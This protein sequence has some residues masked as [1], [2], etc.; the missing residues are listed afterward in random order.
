L[1]AIAAYFAGL[2]LIYVGMIASLLAGLAG[3]VGALPILLISAA[4]Q[5]LQD[6]LLGAAAGIMM[7]AASFSLLVPALDAG[8]AQTGDIL[9]GG[10]LAA[11]GLMLG[12]A[13]ISLAH[14]Y[15]PHEHFFKGRDQF[16]DS[17]VRRIW[18]F[19]IAITLH[20]IPEGLAVGVGFGG[21]NVANGL[22]LTAGIFL[23]NL[24]EGFVVALAL[25]SL[26]YGR[27]TAVLVAL[28]T[29]A[30]ETIGG[31]IGA[32]FVSLSQAFLP[33]GLAGAAGAMLFVISHEIIPETH[34]NGHE[35]E[36]TFGLVAGFAVMMIL[37]VLTAELI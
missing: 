22:A 3:G 14:K 13:G 1:S 20:N 24:P 25:V 23:Q 32:G 8:M 7:A 27:A 4:S 18:L 21:G 19:V 30:V 37:D 11:F 9:T 15:L 36:S 26:G 10:L 29:G 5:R 31:F 33:I 35:G 34:R 2:P 12:A 28:A 17:A 6:V 16:S